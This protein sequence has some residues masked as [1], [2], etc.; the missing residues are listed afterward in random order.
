AEAAAATAHDLVDQVALVKRYRLAQVDTEVLE[1]HSHLVRTAQRAQTRRVTANR[2]GDVDA[3][4]IGQH[5]LVIHRHA[6]PKPASRYEAINA[7]SPG[8]CVTPTSVRPRSTACGALGNSSNSSKSGREHI[9][10]SPFDLSGRIALVTGSSRGIGSAIADGLARSGAGVIIHRREEAPLAP[11]PESACRR[12]PKA[13]GR[14][15]P[16]D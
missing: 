14:N 9:V 3:G 8:R 4:Q 6:P 7:C 12:M 10:T 2:R 15:W 5:G 16:R 1:R 13:G 11:A